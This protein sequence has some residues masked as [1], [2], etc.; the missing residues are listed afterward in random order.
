MSAMLL[1][2][3]AKTLR[4]YAMRTTS[5]PWNSSPVDSPDAIVTSAVYSFA[6]E[7]GSPE[8]E[9]IGAVKKAR[10]GGIRTG[11]DARYIA[12][13]HPP[14]A[15]AL[16]ELLDVEVIHAAVT[17]NG[18]CEPLRD[19]RLALARAILREES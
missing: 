3:A 7:T 10:G 1:R 6:H 8:S 16:A 13:M 12:L 2:S 9:V 17:P 5:G 18:C 15:L 4:E 14:V 11:G 19:A